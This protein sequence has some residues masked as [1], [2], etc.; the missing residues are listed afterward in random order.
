[1]T[2]A[3]H[4]SL[5]PHYPSQ[6]KLFGDCRRRY[7]LKVVERRQVVEP[8][9]P[10]LEKGK[11]AHAVLKLCAARIMHD[12]DASLADLGMLV[13][14]RLPREPYP[15]TP[16]WQSDVDEISAWV[17]YGLAQLDAAATM[18][19]AEL[20]LRRAYAGD[21]A[22][23]PFSLG[24]VLDLVLLRR[25]GDGTPYL[26]VVDYKS[27]RNRWR[28]P[29]APVV[30]R[31]VLKPLIRQNLP[32]DEFGRV[33]YTELYL[34]QQF[35]RRLELERPLCLERWETIKQLIME[36]RAE[37]VF[38]P[39]PSPLCQF[40]PYDGNGCLANVIEAADREEMW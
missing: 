29:L 11:V 15:S 12:S 23:E 34:A 3:S 8:F 1:M 28:D 27:G 32:S 31:F 26:E 22:C 35:A 16:S 33:V 37:R 17:T 25:G 4:A 21:A 36:I 9:S 19:G 30:V 20:F 40:C 7:L 14:A 18:L 24:A 38:P 6:L 13:A 2:T 39:S 5:Q 10:A